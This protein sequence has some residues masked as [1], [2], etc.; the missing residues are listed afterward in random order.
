MSRIC[1]EAEYAEAEYVL[2][3]I[4]ISR[5]SSRDFGYVMS[6]DMTGVENVF[7]APFLF[8]STFCFSACKWD[9]RTKLNLSCDYKSYD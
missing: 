5:H 9:V 2:S 7:P 1:A 3:K 8:E 4:Y 6:A